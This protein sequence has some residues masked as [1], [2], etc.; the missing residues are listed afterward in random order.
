MAVNTAMRGG[1]VVRSA[2]IRGRMRTALL[3]VGSMRPL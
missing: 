1:L 3:S 2:R